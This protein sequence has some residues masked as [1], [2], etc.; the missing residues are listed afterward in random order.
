MSDQRGSTSPSDYDP[1]YEVFRD[2]MPFRVREVLLV[3]SQ[4]DSYI[5]EEDGQLAESLDVEYYQLKLSYAPRITRVSTGEAA[6]ELL[7][8]REFDLIITLTR[9]GGMDVI[10]FARE[11]GARHPEV[12][13]VLLADTPPE[14]N[15]AKQ[16][17]DPP[18]LDQV[19]VWRGDVALFLA[20]IKYIEDLRNVEHD[21]RLAGV[22]TI[23]L[24]ENSVRFYSTYLPRL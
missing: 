21:T 22:R 7:A 4:Y 13:V 5:L 19:F 10:R 1:T 3:S 18:V 15:R 11:V 16:H 14:A 23:I 12:P 2:L 8:Q 6:L 20:I 9:L 24:I 17:N